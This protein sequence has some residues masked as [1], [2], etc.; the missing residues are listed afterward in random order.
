MLKTTPLHSRHQALGAKLVDFSGWE[1]P[2]QYVSLLDEH[3]SVRRQS[4]MFDV[5]HMCVIDLVGD[6]VRPLLQNLLANDVGRLSVTGK[7]L[8]TCMLNPRGGV[9]DDLIV[10]FLSTD[11]FR[12][13]VN[14]GPAD[15]DLAWLADHAAP[16]GVAVIPRRDLGILAVQGPKARVTVAPHLTAELAEK[17]LA[18][19]AFSAVWSDECFVSRTGYTG[20]DGFELIVPHE[21]LISTWD[22]LL[23]D[24]VQ[25]CGLGARDT[26]RLEAGMNLYGQDMDETVTPLECGL[27]WTVVWSPAN[28]HFVGREVLQAQRGRPPRHAVGLVLQDRGVMRAHM[29]IRDA[30]GQEVG[31]VTS[32]C[33]APTLKASIALGRISAHAE[34]PL[35][36]KIRAQWQPVRVVKP[37]F[38]RNGTV[39]V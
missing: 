6:Q 10:Y 8:Y 3:H 4:G 33:F 35:Q 16:Y 21:K 39:L 30:V 12:L 1:M 26:L 38:V 7:A 32:G 28:R 13:I 14:A 17:A 31:T 27:G 9:L 18:M 15:R 36:V 11:R 29:P 19:T 20:E 37:P 24:H 34:M 22:A 25:P 23:T 2:V 5:S